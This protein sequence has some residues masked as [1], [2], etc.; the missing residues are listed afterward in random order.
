MLPMQFSRACKII[1]HY[2]FDKR[3]MTLHALFS[4]RH[5]PFLA[6]L[7]GIM[8]SL[9]TL[10]SGLFLDDYQQRINLLSGADGNL[11]D[12]F[13][14]NTA[15]TKTQ[16]QN[17]VLPW[18]TYPGSKVMFYRPV[19]QWL[20]KLDYRLWPDNLPLMHLHSVLW[21]GV[22][23]LVASLAYRQIMPTHWAAGL[24]AVLFAVDAAHG[25]AV[26]WLANRNAL[27]CL[28]GALLSLLCYRKRQLHWRIVGCALFAFSLACSEAALAI[29][30]YFL[31]Y[32]LFLSDRP[33]NE[34]IVRLLPYSFL[35]MA[36]LAF[37][38]YR[39]FG[40]SGPGFYIDP[41]SDP[42]LFL[43]AMIY[44]FPAYVVGQL[45]IPPA[46]IFNIPEYSKYSW[47]HT[48]A[49][50]YALLVVALLTWL[51]MPLLRRSRT[52]RFYGLGML[53]AVIPICGSA[54]ISRSLWFV[55]FGA[56]GLLAL[57]IE[58]FRSLPMSPARRRCSAAFASAMM[59]L[60]LWISPLLFVG[61]AK[62]GTNV[63]D[64]L[65]DSRYLQLPNEGVPGRK[66]LAISTFSYVSDITF[67]MLKDQALSLGAMPTRPIPSIARIRA[68]AEGEGEFELLR[69]DADTVVVSCAAGFN[70]LRP[71]RYGFTAGDRVVLDDVEIVVRSVSPVGAPTAIEYRFNQGVLG[72]YEVIAW[73]R[74]R[75][76]PAVLPAI[77]ERVS[78]KTDEPCFFCNMWR[79]LERHLSDSMRIKFLE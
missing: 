74:G 15:A 18:W 46:E 67:P 70:A 72:A 54:L 34:R 17:G 19:A 6:L 32:E 1:P 65:M 63:V 9:P 40:I 28:T 66:V 24:A 26:A 55:G 57:F 53:I 7:L 73:Q 79:D 27:P 59:V 3:T 5:I 47:M 68:L 62:A 37:W 23:V 41:I 61:Y 76:E 56:T 11:F 2:I 12:F 77:G 14:S 64:G 20:M 13:H 50:A 52:A 35:A 39:G 33:W 30:A 25:S 58:Q 69:K 60:H 44:R 42:S 10:D 29:T 78:V 51:F 8:V 45:S 38:K 49:F 48:Y 75:F 43:T 4:W 21:Y 16:L 22:L 31:A 71:S 36:W